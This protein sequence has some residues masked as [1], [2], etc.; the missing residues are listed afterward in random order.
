MFSFWSVVSGLIWFSLILGLISAVH[1]V[2]PL[3][4][5]G[6][7]LFLTATALGAF[8]ILFPFDSKA[9]HVIRL[10]DALPAVCQAL[11]TPLWGRITPL[12]LLVFV[13][14]AG[15]V[16]AAVRETL[17]TVKYSRRLRLCRKPLAP[18]LQEVVE[19][20]GLPEQTVF[21]S[22]AADT[23]VSV[24]LL[25]PQIYLPDMPFNREQLRWVLLHEQYHLNHKDSWIKLLFVSLRCV[26]WWDP[27]VRIFG[28]VLDDI[29]EVRCDSG[30]LKDAT[31]WEYQSY[32]SAISHVAEWSPRLA[33][34]RPAQ[35]STFAGIKQKKNILVT[36]VSAIQNLKRR[37]WLHR[38][39]MGF[40]VL[41]CVLVFIGSYFV[42]IQPYYEPE[43]IDA[44]LHV[45]ISP[46]TS[47]IVHT[48][49]DK[50]V[51]WCQD[52]R[53]GAISEDDLEIFPNNELEIIEGTD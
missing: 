29:L 26:L 43:D 45:N 27:P 44:N 49:D 42:I 47:Y 52:I 6:L 18:P 33:A 19:E 1:F 16:V 25:H 48:A 32:S 14:A 38:L 51:L 30:V 8:R 9:A 28:K 39:A 2:T 4:E 15:A 34:K 17:F 40:G 12:H 3:L 20:V 5:N 50:Y 21:V 35:A 13:W 24:G 11:A 7:I 53:M 23:P 41:V 36:R 22:L 31:V 10:L 46:E 37:T